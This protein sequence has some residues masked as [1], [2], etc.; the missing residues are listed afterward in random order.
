MP[1]AH[2][3]LTSCNR[4]HTFAPMVG[5]PQ[6]LSVPGFHSAPSSSIASA[7]EAKAMTGKRRHEPPRLS[8]PMTCRTRLFRRGQFAG[9]AAV[10]GRGR[11]R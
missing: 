8:R 5:Q 1:A 10:A 3:G 7:V 2:N 4:M 11:T 6:V 9:V